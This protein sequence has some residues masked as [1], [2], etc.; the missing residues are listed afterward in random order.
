MS[1]PLRTDHDRLMDAFE[2]LRSIGAR[3]DG[4]IDRRAFNDADMHARRWLIDE[5]RRRGL[6]AELDPAANVLVR[7]AADHPAPPLLIGSHLDSVP[8]GGPFDGALGVVIGLEI[9]TL[10][11]ERDLLPGHP[12]ELAAFSDE[13]GRFGGMLGSRAIAGLLTPED[14]A[15]ATDLDGITLRDAMARHDLDADAALHARRAPG[16][17]RA[18][19]EVHVEQ[20]PVLD[21]SRE[22]L[23]LVTDI[24]G[25][26][27]WHVS[28]KGEPDH[29][30]TTPMPMRRDAFQ[31]LAEFA[32]EIQRLL[33]E[34]GSDVST[35]TIGSVSLR[36]GAANSVPG[37]AIF[38]ID[39][40][41][42]DR[43][44]LDDLADS[45]RRTLSAIA[46]RRGLMFEFDEIERI[47]P[48]PCDPAVVQAVDASARLLGVEPL[49][50]HSGAAHDAQMIAH[51]APMGMIFTPSVGGRSHSPAEWTHR[52]D[53]ELAAD[54]AAGAVLTLA[55]ADASAPPAAPP[56]GAEEHG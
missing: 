52:E 1:H 11:H 2:H 34:H 4:S 38:S 53:I 29:A 26:V 40:R 15:R 35:A 7:A 50:M 17:F 3:P 13:E 12:V 22:R 21:E 31:G 20:G 55:G 41:D 44:V 24:T 48:T 37:E 43:A 16:A 54:V 18:F 14:I 42:T 39:V 19:L 30:G 23:G 56:R 49:R 47:D 6:H 51:I 10:F 33:E 45:M 46:R 25:L 32:T 9:L 28:L 8:S 36:P 27:K 5:A